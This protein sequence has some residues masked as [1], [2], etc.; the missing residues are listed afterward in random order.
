MTSAQPN[1]YNA[2][3]INVLPQA[4]FNSKDTTLLNT[5][6]ANS[7][8]YLTYPQFGT[9]TYYSNYGH[10]TYHGLTSRVE[11]R[12]SNG[13]SYTFLF[14][15][16]KNLQGT[17]GSGQQF[18]DWALTKGPATCLTLKYQFTS[19]GT[20]YDLPFGKHRKFLNRDTTVG[21]ITDIFLGGWS[22]TAIE[23]M[24]TGL[25]VYFTMAGSPNK[26]LPG[27]TIP[28]IVAGQPV[29]VP[30]YAVGPNPVAPNQLP[31][32]VFQ[33]QSVFLSGQFYERQCG[34]GNRTAGRRVVA[35]IFSRA[36]VGPIRGKI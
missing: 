35:G 28:N 29:N 36:E 25:P 24:R 11:R 18:Y 30:N 5:V 4:I 8:S 9:I 10:S 15:W 13:L 33:H 21:Y 16:S 3:N 12:F 22:L 31:E 7:Q 26:Y 34:S 1:P 27:Q 17:A 14:T 6:Y 32:P 23:S 20:T 19:A 2:V